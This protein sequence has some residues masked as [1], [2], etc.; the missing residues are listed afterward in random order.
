MAVPLLAV[1]ATPLDVMA[2]VERV[3][4]ERA[5]RAREADQAAAGAITTFLGTVRDRNQGRR[6]QALDYEAY[7]PMAVRAF[8]RIADEIARE[9]PD[10]VIALHHRTGTLQIGEVSVAIAVASPHRAAAFAACRYAIERVKQI[11]P[12]WKREVFEGGETWIEGAVA[13]PDDEAARTTALKLA[14]A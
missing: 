7:E 5:A 12:I 6:V 3:L 11:A 9:W 10:T 8:E 14:C 2:L 4:A 13:D 1:S